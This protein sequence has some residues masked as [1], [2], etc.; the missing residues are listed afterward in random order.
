[1]QRWGGYTTFA[2]LGRE[3]RSQ[4]SSKGKKPALELEVEAQRTP[5][6]YKVNPII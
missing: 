4:E 1:M 6:F 2:A 5:D 3:G